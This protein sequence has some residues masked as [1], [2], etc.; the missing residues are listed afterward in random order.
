M[1]TDHCARSGRRPR[2]VVQL[3]GH[4]KQVA[5]N[6]QEVYP[7]RIPYWHT[8]L[9]RARR[10]RATRWRRRL[11]ETAV[12]RRRHL[13]FG[14]NADDAATAAAD[15]RRWRQWVP[16]INRSQRDHPKTERARFRLAANDGARSFGA[17]ADDDDV[18]AAAQRGSATGSSKTRGIE[19]TALTARRIPYLRLFHAR[20]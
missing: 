16:P 3:R 13:R 18:A 15:C 12:G 19:R 10:S 17:N 20:A 7:R 11:D 5:L 8:R 6:D 2:S 14:A 9:A 4:R 1:D